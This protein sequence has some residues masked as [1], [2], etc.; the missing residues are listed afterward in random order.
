[1]ASELSVGLATILNI[2]GNYIFLDKNWSPPSTKS[3]LTPTLIVHFAVFLV[4]WKTPLYPVTFRKV[5]KIINDYK[6]Q[7]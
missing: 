6:T 5:C 3:P 4:L 1:M 2:F 7:F